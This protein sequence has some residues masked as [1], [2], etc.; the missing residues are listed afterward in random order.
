ML[1]KINLQPCNKDNLK[2]KFQINFKSSWQNN[3]YEIIGLTKRLSIQTIRRPSSLILSSIQPIIWLVLFG[4]LFQKMMLTVQI[5]YNQFLNTGI[6]I[7]TSFTS[8]MNAG[9]PIIFDREFGF[10]NRLIISPLISKY[11]ILIS[12]IIIITLIALLQTCTIISFNMMILKYQYYIY[13]IIYI[14]CIIVL[15]TITVSNIS[16]CLAFIIP[17]HVEF[18]A[19]VLISNLPILF[20]STALAP[21]S[22]MPKWLQLITCLNPITYAIEILRFILMNHTNSIKIKLLVNNNINIYQSIFIIVLIT[23]TN[24]LLS[25]Y[26]I[27]YKCE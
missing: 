7:F 3:Y 10:F 18:L 14:L 20:S 11:S 6:I 5:P 16:I 12:S 1:N 4:A 24:V 17:G 25:K 2:P 13:Q 8:A 23:M 27:K 9:L 22:F 21:I 26:I 19:L 15:L